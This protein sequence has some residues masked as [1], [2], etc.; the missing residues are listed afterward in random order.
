[1][2]YTISGLTT[3]VSRTEVGADPNPIES[4][5]TAVIKDTVEEG[6]IVT[7]QFD[8]TLT[9]GELEIRMPKVT[10]SG[11]KTWIDS[12]N[13]DGKRPTT[14]QIQLMNHGEEVSGKRITAVV[15]S[16]TGACT[17]EFTDLPLYVDGVLAEYSVKETIE[18]GLARYYEIIYAE[19][20]T[21]SEEKQIS[22]VT[23]QNGDIT[24]DGTV[25][26]AFTADITNKH[27]ICKTSVELI[28]VWD[29]HDNQ[30][31]KRP[32]SIKINLYKGDVLIDSKVIDAE[33]NTVMVEQNNGTLK[34]D[35]NRWFVIF[36]DLDVYDNGERITYRFEE[37]EV[38]SGELDEYE[39]TYYNTDANT[40]NDSVKANENS[41]SGWVRVTNTDTPDTTSVTVTKIWKDDNN[42]DGKRPESIEMVL[43][44]NDGS[45]HVPVTLTAEANAT[46]DPNVWTYTWSD[47]PVYK[48]GEQGVLIRYDVKET[49]AGKITANDST[50]EGSYAM[51]KHEQDWAGHTGPYG[52]DPW[53]YTITNTHV[54][55]KVKIDVT[56]IWNDNKNVSGIRP[57]DGIT[58][59]ITGTANGETVVTDTLNW[60]D[61]MTNPSWHRIFSSSQEV[62][63]YKYCEGELVTYKI[64]E[65]PVQD[66]DTEISEAV[67]SED[68]NTWTFE[69]TNTA[70]E[71][72]LVI[73]KKLNEAFRDDQTF[74]FHVTGP[75]G[76]TIV[77]R[78]V[79]VK[80]PAN[81][82]TG[83]VKLVN[84]PIGD[85][86]VT[87][88]DSW[89]WRWEIAN[90]EELTK[91]VTV[92][93]QAEATVTFNNTLENENWLS[94]TA[95][96]KNIFDGTVTNESG[97]TT[98]SNWTTPVSPFGAAAELFPTEKDEDEKKRKADA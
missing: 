89:S 97:S 15:D 55:E 48:A 9:P 19:V 70:R 67:V 28:K 58:V 96:E 54:P 84:V 18:T 37:V 36:E 31:G 64:S 23:S 86:V 27:E 6:N 90:G 44:K 10:V 71:G 49:L 11:S 57:T 92:E 93:P 95:Y 59:T 79:V 5:E 45:S 2:T 26:T 43:I 41:L 20:T 62:A 14:L 32:A 76:A 16:E 83:S 1:M 39:E 24:E 82:T 4:K 29:D 85:Y 87:E 51:S 61:N 63:Y 72:E 98:T 78:Y 53:A 73:V 17:W 38:N 13:H 88:D 56:K 22:W 74:V 21:T 8:I 60:T 75:N 12:D 40:P 30:D 81:A 35:P 7:D 34:P 69:I 46:D 68:G 47:L 42:R 33:H 52:V 91:T 65:A 3:G 50:S 77:D 66:Y 80:V 25:I 94:G